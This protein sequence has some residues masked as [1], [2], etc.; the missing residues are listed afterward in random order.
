[1]AGDA[2]AGVVPQLGAGRPVNSIFGEGVSPKLRK[3]R[4]AVDLLNLRPR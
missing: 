2:A 3:V 4:Q 1:M